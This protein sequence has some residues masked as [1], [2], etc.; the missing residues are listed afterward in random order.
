MTVMTIITGGGRKVASTSEGWAALDVSHSFFLEILSTYS[1][2]GRTLG[3][4]SDNMMMWNDCMNLILELIHL[5][6]ANID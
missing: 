5:G 3:S 6:V 4:F 1:S 2:F